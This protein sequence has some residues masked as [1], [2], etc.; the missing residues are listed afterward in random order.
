MIS[1][2]QSYLNDFAHLIFP[3]CC[4]GCGSDILEAHH[5]LCS[6]CILKLPETNFIFKPNNPI[7]K[8][9]YGRLNLTSAGAAFY[10]TKDS[11]MQHLMH[12]LKYKNNKDIAIYLGKLLGIQL[13]QS[14]R[15][16]SVDVLVPLPLNPKREAKRGY[17]QAEMI[18]R[19]ISEVMNITIEKKAVQRSVFTQT[20]TNQ[21]RISRWQNMDGVFTIDNIAALQN[22]HVLLVDDIVTTGATLEACGNRIIKNCNAVLSIATV[23]V[24]S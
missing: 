1:T 10:F 4:E 24:T 21:N 14:G 23:A 3:H 7:E 16:D 19:G 17:N 2:I 6:A 13:L 22:K 5:L 9:F 8:I 20:Q 15:F 12:E 11:L 18:C